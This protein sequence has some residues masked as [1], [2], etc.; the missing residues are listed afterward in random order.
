MH[1]VSILS[2]SHHILL[3]VMI[4]VEGCQSEAKKGRREREKKKVSDGGK[5]AKDGENE[6]EKNEKM[7]RIDSHLWTAFD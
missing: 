3:E 2:T 7:R 4:Y 1:Q 5:S 6:M